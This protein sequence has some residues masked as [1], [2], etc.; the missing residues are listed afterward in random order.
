MNEQTIKNLT[1]DVLNS[2]N[3]DE[4]CVILVSTTPVFGGTVEDGA[5]VYSEWSVN[6]RCED[7]SHTF[8]VE[9]P[10]QQSEQKTKELIAQGLRQHLG[11]E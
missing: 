5:E 6:V 8:T 10:A 2:W 1:R 9:T 3:H 7:G 11:R 4:N